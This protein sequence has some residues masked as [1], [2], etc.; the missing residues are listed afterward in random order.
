VLSAC[1]CP[2]IPD[3]DMTPRIPPMRNSLVNPLRMPIIFKAPQSKNK[4]YDDAGKTIAT[5]LA[6]KYLEMH[7]RST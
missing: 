5:F 7:E 4:S 6:V 3:V 1:A 2:T